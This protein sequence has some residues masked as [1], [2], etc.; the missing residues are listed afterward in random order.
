ML[1]ETEYTILSVSDYSRDFLDFDL[2]ANNVIETDDDEDLDWDEKRK[3]ANSACVVE[4]ILAA[5]QIFIYAALR[6]VPTNARIFAILSNRLR[7]AV[8]RPNVNVLELWRQEHNLPVLL[9][10]CVTACSVATSGESR[11]FWIARLVDVTVEL[12]VTSRFD[13]EMALRRVA[14]VD[15]YFNSAMGGI[16]DE[17]AQSRRD[18][19]IVWQNGIV[20]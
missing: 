18:S 15:T 6:D 3:A 5:C 20:H 19:G 13:L 12:N 10:V 4:A 17:I 7:G 1:Y 2:A 16:W 11:A 8:A 9:W 14:W